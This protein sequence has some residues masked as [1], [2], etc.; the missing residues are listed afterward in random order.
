MATQLTGTSKRVVD[1]YT[2]WQGYTKRYRKNWLNYWKLW[3]NQRIK[4][5]YNAKVADSFD[6]MTHQ[7]IESRVDNIY[8]SRPKMTYI[9]TMPEQE[10]DTKLLSG[11]FDYSWDKSSMDMHII[12]I[13]REIE[14]TGNTIVFNGWA[15]GYMTF[16]HV[17]I[18]D[19]IGDATASSP[20]N[21]SKI[22]YRRLALLDDL[23]K[24]K[25]FDPTV[26]EKDDDGNPKGAWVKKY[27][28]LD[29]IKKWSQMDGDKF[30]KR[31]KDE[32]YSGSTL[33]D[34][35][36]D[37]QVEVI[38]MYYFDKIVEIAN[39][40][41]NPIYEKDN[42]FQAPARE[43]EVQLHN[44]DAEPMYDE[45]SLPDGAESMSREQLAATL[46]PAKTKITI[47]AIEPFLPFA[48]GR[49]FI[50]PAVL[51]AKGTVETFADNQEDLNDEIN[52]KKDNL[53]SRQ[54]NNALV[55]TDQF[56]D[57]V[58]K[59]ANAKAN[60]YIPAEGIADGRN[61]VHWIDKPELANDTDIEINRLKQSIRDT[62]R[63][64][65]IVQGID[66]TNN[67]QTATEVN[68]KVAGASSGFNTQTHNL[69]AGLY[70]QL[71][72]NFYKM[73][74][75][76]MTSQQI[77]RIMGKQGVEFKKFDHDNYFGEY[78]CKVA[79]ESEAQAAAKDEAD[80]ALATYKS[81]AGDPDFNQIEL[82]K[83]VAQRTFDMDDDELKLLMN[84]S[85]DNTA[86]QGGSPTGDVTDGSGTPPE[87]ATPQQG[88]PTQPPQPI[89]PP[90]SA[91]A[92]TA[93]SGQVHES[94]DLVKLFVAASNRPDV[95]DQILG[96]LG[97]EATQPPLNVQQ[98]TQDMTHKDANLAMQ[99]QKHELAVEQAQQQAQQP[100]VQPEQPQL[101]VSQ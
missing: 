56:S 31:Q 19:C 87:G 85:T 1:D 62:A 12:P 21:V 20:D 50:D 40:S 42:I 75:I 52:I 3:N 49:N 13:G 94:A 93:P 83:L 18:S 30:D 6:P 78:D 92:V 33:P 57:I 70:K 9:P 4:R 27:K 47:P 63:V 48:M 89:A 73:S 76:F 88:T 100:P 38:R 95:Q 8:G 7:M 97:L 55:D 86:Q 44:E 36:K 28:N 24:E 67:N 39:R 2:A 79:L 61:P 84:T 22:G 32:M 54:Q 96:M 64:A 37:T 41:D 59:L 17:P 23:K 82:K 80:R 65:E 10:K 71:G 98:Q 90:P 5:L 43:V 72:D 101:P 66:T 29:N 25:E 60:D 77:V 35:Q 11:M 81:F 74:Q 45:N 58:P 51:L 14:I 91:T 26:G 99:I 53:I 16:L 46:S 69:E 68:A 15:D 34:E